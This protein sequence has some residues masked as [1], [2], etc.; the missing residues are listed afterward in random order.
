MADAP[1]FF[2]DEE[3]AEWLQAACDEC[4]VDNEFCECGACTECM[5]FGEIALTVD[6]NLGLCVPCAEEME[7]PLININDAMR[8]I[9][10]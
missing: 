2:T 10:S 7:V 4:G 9:I 8:R 5:E 3:A 6:Q 1:E